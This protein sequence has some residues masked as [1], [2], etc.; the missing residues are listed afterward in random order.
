MQ[1]S[2][3][4]ILQLRAGRYTDAAPIYTRLTHI[5]RK[6]IAML[7]IIS[8][9]ELEDDERP[10]PLLHGVIWQKGRIRLRAAVPN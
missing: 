10:P 6:Y 2:F 3:S 5:V 4:T 8:T 9:T 1:K 7:Q